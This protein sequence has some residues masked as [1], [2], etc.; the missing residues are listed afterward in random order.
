MDAVEGAWPVPGGL[1]DGGGA[2][3]ACPCRRSRAGVEALW[4]EWFFSGSGDPVFWWR[5][6]M[7][8]CR[9]RGTRMSSG[10]RVVREI[11]GEGGRTIASVS[12]SQWSAG[13]EE[14]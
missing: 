10:L 12:A 3:A 5:D 13:P 9:E 14:W 2:G 7:G 6:R 8:L 11:A 1:G 4:S